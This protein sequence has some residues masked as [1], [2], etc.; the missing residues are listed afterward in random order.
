[1]AKTDDVDHSLRLVNREEREISADQ[2]ATDFVGPVGVLR[3]QCTAMR[4]LVKRL[5]GVVDSL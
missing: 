3:G 4:R 1:M 2:Q 5:D